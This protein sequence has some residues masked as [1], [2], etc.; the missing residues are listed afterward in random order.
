MRKIVADLH[1]HST[2][3]DGDLSPEEIVIKAAE[4]GLKCFAVTDHDSILGI[5]AALIAGKKNSI[6]VIPGIEVTLRFRR[7][8]FV[9]SLHVL[10]YFSETLFN[11]SDFIANLNKVVSLGRGAALNR[12]R[13]SS[14]NKIFGPQGK[15]PVLKRDLTTSEISALSPNVSRRHFA[16]ALERNHDLSSEQITKLIGN[17]SPAYVPS[18]VDMKEL[19]GL[20]REYPVLAVLAHPAAG[21]FP[22]ESHYKEV[23]P[24]LEI[25]E[26]M[27]PEFFELGV[28]GIEIWYPGHTKEHKAYLSALARQH[29]LIVT[30][31]SDCHD[32]SLRPI[33]Q[34]GITEQELEKVLAAIIA[35]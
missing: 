8:D 25:V 29:N 7:T 17:D 13:V 30:G 14:L 33:G 32:L 12:E 26:K 15:Q 3:S 9:G 11:N 23:L 19:Q 18:G 4:I 35:D 24:P 21:S 1:N 20:I 28:Q 2:F 5:A 34:E 22:G 31:G 27:L 10:L 6:Q 16:M